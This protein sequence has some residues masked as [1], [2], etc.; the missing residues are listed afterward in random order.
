MRPIPI[1]EGWLE[2]NID[3]LPGELLRTIVVAPPSGD[4]TDPNCGAV[5]SMVRLIDNHG[6]GTPGHVLSTLWTLEGDDLAQLLAG[7]Y[8]VLTFMGPMPVHAMDVI[9][10]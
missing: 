7:G 1:P 8:I 9:A 5:E 3:L 10:P 2:R 6:D 4:L